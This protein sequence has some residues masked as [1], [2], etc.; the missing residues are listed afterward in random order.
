M[1]P[2]PPAHSLAQHATL[3]RSQKLARAVVVVRVEELDAAKVDGE[4]SGRKG[5]S[6][7]PAS[8]PAAFRA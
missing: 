2:C 7:S 5:F 4:R 8:T 3:L 6:L 1:I